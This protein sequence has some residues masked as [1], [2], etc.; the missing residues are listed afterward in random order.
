VHHVALPAHLPGQELGGLPRQQL[1]GEALE[2]LSHHDETIGPG[3]A[4]AEMQ[5]R[6]PPVAAATGHTRRQVVAAGHE[7]PKAAPDGWRPRRAKPARRVLSAEA[8][9]LARRPERDQAR[10]NGVSEANK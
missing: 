1:V 3:H 4:R 7:P 8:D 10:P 2:G 9:G 6:Q 5:V